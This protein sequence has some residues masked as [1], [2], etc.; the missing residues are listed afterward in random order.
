MPMVKADVG[1][2]DIGFKSDYAI[3]PDPDKIPDQPSPSTGSVVGAAFRTE[4]IVGSLIVSE[5]NG[6]N[7]YED[8]GVYDPSVDPDVIGGKYDQYYENFKDVRNAPYA[9]ALKVKIDRELEDKRTLASA[10]AYGT[11]WSIGA[12]VVDLP[13]LIPGGTIIKGGK[14]GWSVAKS[15]LAVGASGALDAAATE[16]A[17]HATQETRTGT[18]SAI[19]IGA[20]TILSGLIGAGAAK[21]MNTASRKAIEAKFEQD[22]V[23]L[24]VPDVGP[25]D[26]ANA[27]KAAAGADVVQ[28]L[29]KEQ[30]GISGKAAQALSNVGFNPMIRLSRS[31]STAARNVAANLPEMSVYLKMTE[32]DISQPQAVE[33]YVKQWTLGAVGDAVRQQDELYKALKETGERMSTTEFR[34]RVGRAMRNG[35]ADAKG[36][37]VVS[38]AAKVWRETVF[39]PLKDEAIKA[40][41]LPKDVSTDTAMSYFSRVYNRNKIEANEQGFKDIVRSWAKGAAENEYKK[42]TDTFEAR[43][44]KID[45]S[46]DDLSVS[47]PERLERL[48]ELTRKFEA[49]KERGQRFK[50]IDDKLSDLRSQLNEAQKNKSKAQ[51]EQL[52]GQIKEVLKDAGDDYA[53]FVATRNE[54][55]TRLRNIRNNVTGLAGQVD[56]ARNKIA[57]IEDSNLRR[58][59]RVHRSL[60]ILEEKIAKEGPEAHAEE[61][62][63]LKTDFYKTL[64]RSNAAQDRLAKARLGREEV[65]GSA[66]DTDTVLRLNDADE[67]AQ[68]KFEAAEVKRLEELS[69]R[70]AQIEELEGVDPE[71]VV[72]ELRDLVDARIAHAAEVIKNENIRL[73]KLAQKAES[74]TPELAKARIKRLQDL[75]AK[76]ERRYADAVDIKLGAD[77]GFKTYSDDIADSIFNQVTGRDT[78]TDPTNLVPAVRGPLKERT[79]NIQDKLIEEFLESDVEMVGRRYARLMGAD[80]ELTRKFGKADMKE[81]IAALQE[82]YASIRQSVE[83]DTKLTEAQ[84]TKRLKELN[85]A[86]KADRRDIE[87]LRDRLRGTYKLEDKV[88]VPGRVVNAVN[89]FNYLRAMGG[90]TLSSLPDIGRSIMVHGLNRWMKD[91][92]G[93]LATNLKGFKLSVKEAKLAGAAAEMVNNT[94]MATFAELTDPYAFGHPVERWLHNAATGFSKLNGMIYWNDFQKSFASVITQNRILENAETALSK[95][96]QALPAKERKYMSFLGLG[97]G[98][99]QKVAKLAAKH[100]DNEDGVRVANTQRWTEDGDAGVYAQRIYRAA[101]NKDVDSII[102]TKGIGDTPLFADTNTGK[103][104]LQFKSFM[105]ASH[106]RMLMRGVQEDAA[107]VFSGMMVATGVGMMVFALKQLEANREVPTNPGRWMAEGIDRSGM[108]GVLME[109]N[110]I[111]EKITGMGLYTAMQ[112]PF[113]EGAAPASRYA[114]RSSVGSLMGPTFG[115]ASDTVG[116]LGAAS[117]GDF[118]EADINSA[119]RLMPGR[120]LPIIK[121]LFE[122]H[123]LPAA[124]EAVN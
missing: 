38:K 108:L 74:R 89:T 70:S 93:P 37:Q 115:L 29:T 84:R 67:A 54:L 88:S 81:Q 62:A 55:S 17:L 105:F 104:I 103:M 87:A 11:I 26:M 59:E 8:D 58:L 12:G 5:T 19:N 116:V 32:A 97:D 113:G 13:T 63:R 40:G 23:N 111:G 106:Q 4:N 48:N 6:L 39:D 10:G 22:L 9:D 21:M 28:G 60:N 71:L 61:L 44:A 121:S 79:F 41:L 90:V 120:T 7:A 107:G 78:L 69:K 96:F 64:E 30:L 114:I 77:D 36:N 122:Y 56:A 49:E 18:E 31:M 46:I 68:A 100:A 94:R 80:V 91:G 15:A 95:G 72:Q 65:A 117:K 92:I 16:V 66:Q 42:L 50:P 14:V 123:A 35:D 110:N 20:A 57:D 47:G 75:L 27:A 82:E 102:V 83:A 98:E 99:A 1:L 76:Y 73:Y 3:T 52:T 85:S 34:E 43:K 112:A 86:E 53:S 124:R 118:T 101:V 2:Q 45:Q 109:M 33:T 24:D 51:A 25:H 119:A